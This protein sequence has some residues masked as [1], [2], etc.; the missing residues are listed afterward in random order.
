MSSPQSSPDASR[1]RRL[2]RRDFVLSSA[3][4]VPAMGSGVLAQESR[5]NAGDNP[6]L[7]S[8][9]TSS[10]PK[11]L[12]HSSHLAVGLA[13][14]RPSFNF[15]SVDSLGGGKVDWNPMLSLE[16]DP[17]IA[18]LEAAGHGVFNYY[19]MFDASSPIPWWTVEVGPK[20]IVLRSRYHAVAHSIR[21][22]GLETGGAFYISFRQQACHATVLGLMTPGDSRVELPCVL[23]LPNMGSVRITGTVPEMKL[24]YT[25]QRHVD[26][27]MVRF[28]HLMFPAAT[29]EHQEVEYRLE[30]AALYP[31]LPGIEADPRFDGFRR[32]FLNGFQI[33]TRFQMLGTNSSSDCCP[34][35]LFMFAEMALPRVRLAEGLYT[36]DLV[37]MT[38]D[39]Y[40]G[41]FKGYG[42][43][44]YEG[45]TS[46]G[47]YQFSD[48]D[49]SLIM[50]SALY[51]R[52][53]GDWDWARR[54]Y[55]K[56]MGRCSEMLRTDSTGNG[57]IKY[58]R[59][60]NS[61]DR[62]R[63]SSERPAN[64]W[65]TINFGYEDAY[66]NTLAYR[67]LRLWAE[68][69]DKLGFSDD[70]TW[71]NAKADKLKAAY[72]RSFLNSATGV[73]A[74]WRSA[75]GQLHDY[76]FLFINSMA[77]AYGVIDDDLGRTIMNLF[78]RKL[79]E[80]GYTDFSHGLPGNLVPIP[81]RDSVL[82][83]RPGDDPRVSGVPVEEDGTEVF[84]RY[85]N[86]GASMRYAYYTLWALYRLGMVEDAR[87]MFYPMLEGYKKELY[88]GFDA[89]GRSR[90]W[91]D[92]R[93]GQAGGY[94]GFAVGNYLPLLA[95]L[96][97]W[98]LRKA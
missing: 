43:P 30:V 26:P 69:S 11:P 50:G 1:T 60:G 46:T 73:I 35:T 20:Q 90:D 38:A 81:R 96:D 22:V 27:P 48:V 85:E 39:R 4:A 97:E 37:R 24:L 52:S 13:P 72:L 6:P 21:S 71:L 98:K 29:V 56:V 2:S 31:E 55:Q 47:P 94:E 92:W 15:F 87:R 40:L 63:M 12:Y 58:G 45:H 59:T 65:D 41:G 82:M 78:L 70:A 42:E 51:A 33:V 80:I 93:K 86:G 16:T 9:L 53:T 88:S 8:S 84:G 74:G 62:P 36:S 34:F 49:P 95:V 83:D 91:W 75:D 32:D 68:V 79:A 76:W 61:N 64:W 18:R 17:P 23:H 77:V 89:A 57:L 19:A 54:Q 5:N 44:G 7:A 10:E 66:A 14:S 67:A 28:V 25:A 3:L